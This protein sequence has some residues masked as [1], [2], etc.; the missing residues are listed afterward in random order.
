LTIKLKLIKHTFKNLNDNSHLTKNMAVLNLEN[1]DQ[2]RM[3][4]RAYILTHT[5]KPT[6]NIIVTAYKR[7]ELSKN[8]SVVCGKAK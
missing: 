4:C 1:N 6:Y 5:N 2:E 7:R 8:N 3:I